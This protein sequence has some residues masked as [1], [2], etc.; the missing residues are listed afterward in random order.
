[1]V[2]DLK[3]NFYFRR[4]GHELSV[5]D[6]RHVQ[7]RLAGHSAELLFVLVRE[8][9]DS[10]DPALDDHLGAL[11]AWKQRH[12]DFAA[13]HALRVLVEDGVHLRVTHVHVLVLQSDK[14]PPVKSG[15]FQ[16]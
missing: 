10:P 9:D 5:G 13:L 12:V 6:P 3:V 15:Q 14:Y 8:V 16:Y 4:F 1:M 7:H 2:D 11:V